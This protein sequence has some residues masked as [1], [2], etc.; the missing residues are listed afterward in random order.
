MADA[1]ELISYS[2]ILW[3]IVVLICVPHMFEC[4]GL[5]I[6]DMNSLVIYLPQ[7]NVGLPSLPWFPSFTAPCKAMRS[8]NPLRAA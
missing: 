5:F 2:P 4:S 3:I 6:K 1:A 8:V 7:I